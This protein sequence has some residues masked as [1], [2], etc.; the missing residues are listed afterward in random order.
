MESIGSQNAAGYTAP[1]KVA[2]VE[3][4]SVTGFHHQRSTQQNRVD[5]RCIAKNLLG[6]LTTTQAVVTGAPATD[7]FDLLTPPT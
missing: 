4:V 6:G 1:P 5:A 7:L 2:Y 3:T